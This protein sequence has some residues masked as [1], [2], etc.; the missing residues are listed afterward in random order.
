MGQCIDCPRITD[1]TGMSRCCMDDQMRG[2]TFDVARER[3]ALQARD[4]SDTLLLRI[5]GR[6]AERGEVTHK[7]FKDMN[8]AERRAF[9]SNKSR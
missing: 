4:K 2:Y 6:S 1:R 8:R 9:L 7:A 3:E 5:P